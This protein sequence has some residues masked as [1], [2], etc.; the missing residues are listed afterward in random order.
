MSDENNHHYGNG[1]KKPRQPSFRYKHFCVYCCTYVQ[2]QNRERHMKQ[3]HKDVANEGGKM[4]P[5]L[6]PAKYLRQANQPNLPAG[7]SLI[8]PSSTT[9]GHLEPATLLGIYCDI[10]RRVKQKAKMDCPTCVANMAYEGLFAPQTDHSSGCGRLPGELVVKYLAAVLKE[11]EQLALQFDTA[12]LI[13]LAYN[14]QVLL[15][16]IR[17]SSY[18]G[19]SEDCCGPFSV[20]Y[21]NL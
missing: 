3:M 16:S 5:C 14:V 12:G 20:T 21:T 9:T 1:N 10:A 2:S 17:D 19:D 15:P 13:Q 6:V 7:Q 4:V 11:P 18:D 8:T